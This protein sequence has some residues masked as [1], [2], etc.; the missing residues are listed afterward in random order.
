MSSPYFFMTFLHQYLHPIHIY[1]F[2][3]SLPLN[4]TPMLASVLG[5]SNVLEIYWPYK[6]KHDISKLVSLVQATALPVSYDIVP[7]IW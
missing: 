6:H 3:L 4:Q 7:N 2:I 1:L 5:K